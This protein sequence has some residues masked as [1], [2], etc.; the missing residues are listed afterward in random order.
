MIDRGRSGGT[1]RACAR[2]R[3]ARAKPG[4]TRHT[5]LVAR[6]GQRVGQ[7]HCQAQTT[8]GRFHENRAAVRTRVGLTEAGDL[9]LIEEVW[10]ENSPWYRGVVQQGRLR[11]AQGSFTKAFVPLGGVS[12]W[13]ASDRLVNNPA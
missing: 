8:I 4:P 11:V 5:R 9:R 1:R 3:C 2:R 13:A 10:E 12:I 6:I 7:S